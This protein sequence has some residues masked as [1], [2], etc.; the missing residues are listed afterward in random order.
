MSDFHGITLLII[1]ILVLVSGGTGALIQSLIFTY[2]KRTQMIGR[3]VDIFPAFSDAAGAPS[4]RSDLKITDG[5]TE[6]PYSRLRIAQIQLTNQGDYNYEEFKFGLTLSEGNSAVSL[7][8]Q[9]PD[10]H[11]SVKQITALTFTEPKSEI[12]L[13]LCPL[14]KKGTY[15]LRLLILVEDAN[16][17]PGEIQFS[18]PL[19]V[20]FVHLPTTT[21]ILEQAVR[22]TTLGIGPFSISF[23]Q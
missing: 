12:D 11:H 6:Y 5:K 22:S 13:I 14:N 1:A 23:P 18:S 4:Y 20:E 15:S 16:Q 7:E 3:R 17:E 2:R 10:R 21:E 19:D 9:T 8:V